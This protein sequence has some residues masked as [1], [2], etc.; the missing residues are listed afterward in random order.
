MYDERDAILVENKFCVKCHDQI[1]ENL[2]ICYLCLYNDLNKSYIN[3]IYC[4]KCADGEDEDHS[5]DKS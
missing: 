2:H 4:E 1:K 3:A 5:D